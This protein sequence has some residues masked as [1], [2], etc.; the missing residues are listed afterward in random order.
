MLNF[1][2]HRPQPGETAARSTGLH[3]WHLHPETLSDSLCQLERQLRAGSFQLVGECGLDKCCATPFALQEEAF[4]RQLQMA[5][6]LEM[7]VVVHCVHAF[8]ELIALREAPLLSSPTANE[9]LPADCHWQQ[10]WVVHGFTGSAQ[11]AHQLLRAGI[12]V[13]FGAAILD[14][15]RVKVREALLS[16]GEDNPPEESTISASRGKNISLTR[17]IS[18]GACFL[19]E[20]DNSPHSIQEI[21]TC[22]AALLHCPVEGLEHAIDQLFLSLTSR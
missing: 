11:L 19:L 4:L 21:Y 1:H 16:L 6:R 5:E 17:K 2:T 13:S 7:P 3:P 14:S 18:H 20:T 8:N 22:A 15:R 9:K 12:F 10:P